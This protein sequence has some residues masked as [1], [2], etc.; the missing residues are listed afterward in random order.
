MIGVNTGERSDQNE[1]A[2]R[3]RDRHGLTY[4]ILLDVGDKIAE[5]YGLEAYPTNVIID[6]TGVVR[7]IDAGFDEEAV[8]KLI[9][10]LTR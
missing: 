2:A 8:R 3:F 4:P 7:Y 10:R 6:G 1:A 5:L 9:D